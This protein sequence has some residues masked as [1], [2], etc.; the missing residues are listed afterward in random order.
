MLAG[1]QRE[2]GAAQQGLRGHQVGVLPGKAQ[3]H[4]AIGHGLEEQKRIGRPAAGYA[5]R[6]VHLIFVQPH[7]AANGVKE[8]FRKGLFA[9]VSVCSMHSAVIPAP[10]MAGVLGITRRNRASS[11][12]SAFSVATVS[13]ATME[14]TALPA[15]AARFSRSTLGATLGFTASRITSLARIS[16]SA[17]EK[18]TAPHSCSRRRIVST[19]TS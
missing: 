4:A 16:A 5:H 13:P 1:F 15:N 10:A 6:A 9:S 3:G 2:L 8:R 19:F 7:G 18:G 12:R 17:L 14:I 11:G